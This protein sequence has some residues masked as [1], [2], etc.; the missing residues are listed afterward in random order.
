[1]D[2][3]DLSTEGVVTISRVL[4][5]AQ[6]YVAGEQLNPVWKL[7]HDG[8]AQIANA[9]F[10]YATDIHLFV[11]CAINPAHQNPNLPVAFCAK[12]QLMDQLSKCLERMGK[13]V[14]VRFF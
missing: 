13:K 14:T 11:G 9:L 2:G 10:D 1:M 5:Y 6:E 4:E 8:A 12:F 3:V 7:S